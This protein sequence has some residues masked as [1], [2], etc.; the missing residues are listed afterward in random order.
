MRHDFSGTE[1]PVASCLSLEKADDLV[2]E[3]T[4]L[5]A[6]K[7]ISP[8]ESYFYSTVVIFYDS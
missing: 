1:V 3:Y 4:Q 7:G 8:D 6:D 2:G 5:F